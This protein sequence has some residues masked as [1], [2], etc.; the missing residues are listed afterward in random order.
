MQR[1]WEIVAYFYNTLYMYRSLFGYYPAV[2]WL[3]GWITVSPTSHSYRPVPSCALE[4]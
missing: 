2:G 4:T 1:T 3:V